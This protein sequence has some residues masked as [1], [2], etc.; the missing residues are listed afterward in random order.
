MLFLALPD[1]KQ[2]KRQ[3]D[4]EDKERM[5]KGGETEGEEKRKAF[6]SGEVF[7]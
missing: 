7:C 3:S 2:V 4:D 6:C 1:P 5:N